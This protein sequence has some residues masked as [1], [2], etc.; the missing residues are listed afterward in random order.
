MRKCN[1]EKKIDF[2]LNELIVCFNMCK[3]D[4]IK[5]SLKFPETSLL[6]IR[7]HIERSI[8][9]LCMLDDFVVEEKSTYYCL[10]EIERNVNY[11]IEERKR[12]EHENG[13]K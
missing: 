9:Y 13:N 8:S 10:S 11:F 5:D 2:A 1:L 6:L 7:Y 3:P 12:K 4:E